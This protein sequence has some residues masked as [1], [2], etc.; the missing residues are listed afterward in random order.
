M[1]NWFVETLCGLGLVVEGGDGGGGRRKQHL[2]M[3]AS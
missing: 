3:V 1:E 2:D